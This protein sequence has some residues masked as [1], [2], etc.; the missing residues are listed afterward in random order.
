MGANYSTGA[1]GVADALATPGQ[2]YVLTAVSSS[3]IE[4]A[5]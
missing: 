3:T 1:V 4:G 5:L 2:A